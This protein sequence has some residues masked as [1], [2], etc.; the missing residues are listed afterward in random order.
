MFL[1]KKSLA[2]VGL[3]ICDPRGLE[4]EQDCG[5]YK[6]VWELACQNTL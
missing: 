6:G 1:I 4:L 2:K 5:E 3:L